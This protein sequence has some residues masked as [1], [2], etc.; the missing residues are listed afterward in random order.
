MLAYLSCS[1]LSFSKPPNGGHGQYTINNHT[2]ER[3]VF[4]EILLLKRLLILC[5]QPCVMKRGQ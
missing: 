1:A 5:N 3:Y 4:K 2:K